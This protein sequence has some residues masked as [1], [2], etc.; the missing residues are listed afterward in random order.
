M[1]RDLEAQ[2][3]ADF[4]HLFWQRSLPLNQSS[5]CD[6]ICIMDGWEPILRQL[7]Q[8]LTNILVNDMGLNLASLEAR[9]YSFTQVKEKF[10]GLRTYMS[11]ST[12]AM[13]S[14]IRSAG[15]KSDRTCEWCGAPGKLTPKP[16]GR[17]TTLCT[18]CAETAS[19]RW[20]R[21]PLPTQ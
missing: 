18:N 15:R 5:M 9:R 2:L 7:C 11:D 16:P 20:Q 3:Y 17:V 21:R 13:K 12:S 10:G 19:N 14:A 1:R 8:R 6:G 4:P